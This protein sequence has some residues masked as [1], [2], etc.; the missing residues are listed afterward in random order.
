MASTRQF[1][2]SWSGGE[3]APELFGRL[4]DARYQQGAEKLRNFIGRLGGSLQRR[5][6]FDYVRS[7]KDSGSKRS[8]LIPFVYST[9]QAYV[10]EMGEGYFRFHTDG[11]TLLHADA[12]QIASVDTGGDT[13]T[14]T[15]PHGWVSNDAV[16][17]LNTGGGVP[18]GLTAGTTY[19]A[20]PVDTHT[21][22][23]GAFSGP[24]STVDI[25]GTGTGTNY[26]YK[27]S[28]LPAD[29]LGAKAAGAV[30]GTVTFVDVGTDEVTISPDHGMTTG[31]PI[32][33]TTTAFASAAG[34]E[35]LDSTTAY[36]AIVTAPNRIRVA[37]TLANALA[38]V[39]INFVSGTITGTPLAYRMQAL[40]TGTAHGFA[41]GDRVRFTVSSGLMYG[42]IAPDTD[43]TVTVESPTMFRID[44]VALNVN[45]FTGVT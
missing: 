13:I 14:F 6:G 43:Y 18:A 30:G 10:L 26:G 7:T 40:Q 8:R 36:Y 37:T 42:G 44:G 1:I 45:A 4:D 28:T 12:R 34:F 27:K 21:V 41:T 22:Q 38:G 25:T 29:Y 17:F 11:A 24:I 5:P 20:I 23:L 2:R 16:L 33:F 15:T 31:Q 3:I 39:A 35:G 19:Y 9:G 32:R